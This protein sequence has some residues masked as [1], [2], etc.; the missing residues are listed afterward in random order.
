LR[1]QGLQM[2]RGATECTLSHC[3]TCGRATRFGTVGERTSPSPLSLV[4]ATG[5][6]LPAGCSVAL[7]TLAR[8]DVQ[9]ESPG[10]RPRHW[11]WANWSA[12][13]GSELKAAV[14]EEPTLSGLF[15]CGGGPR[16]SSAMMIWCSS[17]AGPPLVTSSGVKR[18]GRVRMQLWR[19]RV[20][21]LPGPVVSTHQS[22]ESQTCT[23]IYVVCC[24]VWSLRQ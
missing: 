15:V 4:G 1:L 3:P 7:F 23:G 14:T 24:I 17:T 2:R 10:T 19:M 13:S 6:G 18:A 22:C 20:R 5:Q 16:N 21:P 8:G 11:Q 12:L 9:S